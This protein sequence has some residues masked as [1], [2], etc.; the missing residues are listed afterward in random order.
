MVIGIG[1]ST[2][3]RSKHLD[4]ILFSIKKFTK[5]PYHLVVANDGSLDNTINICKNHGVSVIGSCNKGIAF[6]KNRALYALSEFTDSDTIIMLEDDTMPIYPGWEQLWVKAVKNFG[7]VTYAHP[8]IADGISQG[9]GT[10]DNPYACMKITSQC[11]GVS[12]KSLKKV[13]YFDTR[14]KGYGIEDGEWTTRL[15]NSGFGYIKVPQED[16]YTKENCM[17][18]GAVQT[19][20]VESYRDNASVA[21]NREIFSQIRNDPIPRAAWLNEEEEELLKTDIKEGIKLICKVW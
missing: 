2:Y 18:T 19:F 15:R 20:D 8:K 17:I 7:Y 13:G 5:S 6:N 14:F 9:E 1:I 4:R 10:P 3:N 11:A 21:K 12:I 16:G